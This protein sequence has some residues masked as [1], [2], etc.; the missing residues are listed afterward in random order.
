M[1]QKILLVNHIKKHF[2]AF[3]QQV[4][5]IDN[6]SLSIDKNSFTSVLGPS[7]CGKSTLL[8][9]VA[10]LLQPNS[11][12][13]IFKNQKVISPPDGIAIVF[14]DANLMPW[15]SVTEN[16]SLPL[17]VSRKHTKIQAQ[18]MTKEMIDLVRLNGFEE[19]Y[20]SNLSGGMAQRVSLARALIQS[21]DVLLL[22]EPF[23]ALDAITRE[24]M[25]EEL[26][27]VWRQKKQTILMITHSIQE[28]V[29]L[30]DRIIV[31][32][33]APAKIV[34]D[35]TID[36]PRPRNNK[37]RYTEVFGNYIKQIYMAIE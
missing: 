24:R 23:G 18:K 21:P 29:F 9:M 1:N 16:I 5:V 8:R 26:L 33:K 28:A 10:G 15:R 14:Q 13:I 4:D 17:E 25:G 2:G 19:T 36:L 7:G 11:G 31:L 20:P 37:F 32:S 22:D 12:E 27:R 30:S 34:L 35:I 6:I 3:N